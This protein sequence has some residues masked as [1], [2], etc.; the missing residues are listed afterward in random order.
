MESTHRLE[1]AKRQTSRDTRDNVGSKKHA[2]PGEQEES[3]VRTVIESEQA[4]ITHV[5][6]CA[7]GVT[8]RDSEKK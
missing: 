5:L 2:P 7:K 8:D 6:E 4:M 3:Q 1:R